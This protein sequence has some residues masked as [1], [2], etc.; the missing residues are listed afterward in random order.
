MRV[1]RSTAVLAR[2]VWR[3]WRA[4]QLRFRLETFGLY[5][6]ALPYARPWWRVSPR[7]VAL[8]LRHGVTYARWVLAM[9]EVRRSGVEAAWEGRP[10]SADWLRAQDPP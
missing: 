2:H 6:P 9:E 10:V 7:S 4:G 8:L 3:V 1:V 5:Y